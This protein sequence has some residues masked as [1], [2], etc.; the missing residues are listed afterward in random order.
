MCHQQYVIGLKYGDSLGL[1]DLLHLFIHG[2]CG[3]I[4][5][6]HRQRMAVNTPSRLPCCT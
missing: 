2:G 4:M 1:T 3:G 5:A 6:G